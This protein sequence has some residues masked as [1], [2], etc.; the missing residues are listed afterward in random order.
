MPL[1]LLGSVAPSPLQ[2]STP[3]G[4]AAGGAGGGGAK[5]GGGGGAKADGKAR[6]LGAAANDSDFDASEMLSTI[7]RGGA[8]DE[9]SVGLRMNDVAIVQRSD[10]SWSYGKLVEISTGED[11]G[12]EISGG[13]L[14]FQVDPEDE[15]MCKI[16]CVEEF[17]KI[18]VL[19]S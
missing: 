11:K 14:E 10:G 6:E 2:P 4:G 9:A 5:G 3:K 17:N 7:Y 8:V 18:R 1:S 12:A 19:R 15:D 13:S 16:F